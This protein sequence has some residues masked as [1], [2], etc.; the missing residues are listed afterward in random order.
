VRSRPAESDQAVESQAVDSS[1]AET[2]MPGKGAIDGANRRTVVVALQTQDVT[3][4]TRA[5][6]V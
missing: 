2:R 6:G 3:V 1:A 4:K 5:A